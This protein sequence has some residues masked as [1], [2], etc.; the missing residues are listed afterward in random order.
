MLDAVLTMTG[1]L[2]SFYAAFRGSDDHLSMAMRKIEKF[3][4][5]GG[6]MPEDPVP[7]FNMAFGPPPDIWGW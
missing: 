1:D 5:M 6:S 7:P 3:T 4:G 2:R